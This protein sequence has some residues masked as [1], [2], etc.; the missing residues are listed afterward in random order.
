MSPRSGR[1]AAAALITAALVVGAAACGGGKSDSGG[2]SAAGD[3]RKGA[4][5]AYWNA[6][7]AIGDA[8]QR[9]PDDGTFVA[10]GGSSS[11]SLRYS[12]YMLLMG[13]S[14]KQPGFAAA[15]TQR[16]TAAGWHPA[17]TYQGLPS[18]TRKGETA[19]LKPVKS[20]ATASQPTIGLTVL[21]PCT[22]AG[23]AAKGLL[24]TY[25]SSADKLKSPTSSDPSPAPTAFPDR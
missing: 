10:C 19:V 21:S 18:A 17:G 12:A 8:A 15:V 25:S 9:R 4:V 23:G 16:L 6:Y 2:K 13:T 3:A 7:Y 1:G 20:Q 14:S 24:D 22:K 11:D 5:A